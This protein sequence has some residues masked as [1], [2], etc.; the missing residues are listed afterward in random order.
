MMTSAPLRVTEEQVAAAQ[1][2]LVLD[3]KLGRQTPE[4]VRQIAAMTGVVPVERKRTSP[5]ASLSITEVTIPMRI[6]EI[7]RQKGEEQ[8]PAEELKGTIPLPSTRQDPEWAPEVDPLVGHREDVDQPWWAL[9]MGKAGSSE[10]LPDRAELVTQL[11]VLGP[12]HPDALVTRANL[13]SWLGELGDPASAAAA[14][15]QVLIDQLR[16]LGP[17]HPDALA[18]RANLASWRDKAGTQMR[19]P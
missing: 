19:K 1:L 6:S 4:V 16:V 11:R 3:E 12:D 5:P 14:L 8:P 7:P 15:E 9:L 10:S 17:D 13:A 2:R 18:T